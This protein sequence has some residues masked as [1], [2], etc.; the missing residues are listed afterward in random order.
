MK[1]ELDR[2]LSYCQAVDLQAFF[3]KH[4]VIAK[5]LLDMTSHKNVICHCC[6]CGG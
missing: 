3:H 6:N 1:R 2:Q 5:H 4:R